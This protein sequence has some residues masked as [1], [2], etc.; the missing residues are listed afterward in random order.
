MEMR[1]ITFVQPN[2]VHFKP[3]RKQGHKHKYTH[4]NF[5]QKKY[6]KIKNHA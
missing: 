5:D 4:E 2:P 6:E 3:V 1:G